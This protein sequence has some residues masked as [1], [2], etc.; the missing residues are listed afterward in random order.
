M[1]RGTKSLLITAIQA[2]AIAPVA[3]WITI[4][5]FVSSWPDLGSLIFGRNYFFSN[6]W[7]VGLGLDFLVAF[8]ALFVSIRCISW[9]IKKFWLDD[10]VVPA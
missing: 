1:K 3:F 4:C 8:T 10:S 6:V 9:L 7:L 2:L 5:W